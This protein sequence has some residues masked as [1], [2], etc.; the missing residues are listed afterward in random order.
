[1]I[2]LDYVTALRVEISDTID[3]GIT[4]IK[5]SPDK[6]V[7]TGSTGQDIGTTIASGVED[8]VAIASVQPIGSS[9]PYERVV[10]SP[11]LYQ[12]ISAPPSSTSLPAPPRRISL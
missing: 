9:M 6:G 1:M 5:V 3:T 4:D 8:V 11:A 10:T 12:I 7:G 2:E